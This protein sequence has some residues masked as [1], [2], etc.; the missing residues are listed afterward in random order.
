MIGEGMAEEGGSGRRQKLRDSFIAG[1][2]DAFTDEALLELLLNYAIL[3]GDLQSIAHKLLKEYGDLDSVLA[4]DFDALCKFKGVKSYTATLLKLADHLRS[5]QR[6][7][8]SSARV[9][10]KTAQQKIAEYGPTEGLNA[11]AVRPKEVSSPKKK[12]VRPKSE[13]FT[14]SVLKEAIEI[15]PKLPDTEDFEAIRDFIKEKLPFSSQN[16]RERYVPYIVNRLFPDNKADTALRSFAKH[17]PLTQELRDACFYR[18]CKAE[19]IMSPICSDLLIP[20]IGY[21]RLD[22]SVIREYLASR[23]P[24][25]KVIDLSAKAIIDSLVA[26][27]VVKSDR[28]SISFG[29]RQP[30]IT[31]LAF[32]IHSEFPEPG[33]YEISKIEQNPA[34]RVMIWNPDQILKGLYELRNVGLIAKI[35]EIDSFRQFTTRY[36]LDELVEH[37][38]SQGPERR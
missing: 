31:S 29:Y 3:R 7:E 24:S 13:L 20:A 19:P 32:V 36:T 17:Y 21:G 5:S 37:L 23:H 12:P 1:E 9:V 28:K 26:G 35:S 11:E 34:I 10:S 14:N 15:L 38:K 4:S 30:S 27:G 22:R 18:F 33:M 25:S 8:A 6:F 2:P 16:T